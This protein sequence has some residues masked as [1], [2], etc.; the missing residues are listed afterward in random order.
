METVL[1]TGAAGFIGSN[2]VPALLKEGYRVVGVDNFD[3][4]YDPA[5][6]E[7]HV[8]AFLNDPNFTLVRADLRD[9]AAIAELFAK[10]APTRV[11]H[12]AAKADTRAAVNDPYPYVD[13][14]IVAT[15]NLLE[16]IKATPSVLNTVLASSSSVY[17]ND[18]QVPW[19]E[20]AAADRPLS[21]YGVTK[22]ATE[23]LAH[24]YHH[25]FGLPITCLRYFNAYGEHNRP[26]MVPYKWAVALLRGE[27]IELS[28][29]GTRERDYTYVGDTV[30]AT[31]KALKKPLGFEIINVGNNRPLSLNELLALFE[32][33]IG[34]KAVVKTRES[35]KASVE[36][37]YADTSKAKALLGWE[38]TTPAKE[39]F[40]RLVAWVRANR[41]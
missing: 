7:E 4:T 24:A 6:K 3:D 19:S 2:L 35:N 14:N 18:P 33:I 21:Q 13:N 40:G 27:E 34:V 25:N 1:V 32:K 23:L 5:F 41:L 8:S 15:V 36:R 28:G 9:K 20:D 12:L 11:V 10:E 37:T 17:G 38:P 30:D 29:G 22:R 26:N 39:G 31:I 16:V